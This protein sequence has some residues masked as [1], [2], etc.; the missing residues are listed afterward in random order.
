MA[1][2]E[3]V[4]GQDLEV[5]EWLGVSC[6]TFK[7]EAGARTDEKTRQ[8]YSIMPNKGF[9]ASRKRSERYAISVLDMIVAHSNNPGFPSIVEIKIAEPYYDD[10]Q[11]AASEVFKKAD[12]QRR[13]YTIV[14]DN[15]KLIV[16]AVALAAAA[17]AFYIPY[18]YIK[19][20]I[21]DPGAIKNVRYAAGS[22]H[23][24]MDGLKNLLYSVEHLIKCASAGIVVG[25]AGGYLSYRGLKAGANKLI[26]LGQ[27]AYD[28]G[29]IKAA[30]VNAQRM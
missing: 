18:Y 20:V 16:G 13:Y 15:A 12:R 2:D 8:V 19:D 25:A 30:V 5:M 7:A 14:R 24:L 22:P 9:F 29:K 10:F 21:P 26:P 11:Q 28:Y 4:E 17:A 1:I 27:K 6:E 23:Y 3:L